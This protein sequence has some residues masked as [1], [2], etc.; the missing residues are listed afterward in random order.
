[1][2]IQGLKGA[3]AKACLYLFISCFFLSS[4]L[5]AGQFTVH[6]PITV[7]R[8]NG[9]PTY[10]EYQFSVDVPGDYTVTI[11]NGGLEDNETLGE[12]VSSSTVKL[13][14]VGIFGPHNFH[15]NISSLTKTV[16]LLENNRLSV[17]I[18]GKPGGAITLVFQGV[19]N[20]NPTISIQ[21]TPE[22]NSAGWNNTDVSINFSCLDDFSG[23]QSC[24]DDL[25]LSNEGRNIE[26]TG[27]AID[28][29]GNSQSAS[30]LLNIDKTV[31]TVAFITPVTETPTSIV[32]LSINDNFDLD[33]GSI[34]LTLDN[35][36]VTSL[37]TQIEAQ[38]SCDFS[39]VELIEADFKVSAKDLADNVGTYTQ[40]YIFDTDLDGDGIGD[41]FDE[42]IDGDGINNDADAFPFDPTESV[43]T[44]NDGIGN[45]MDT[46]DD[47]DG[48]AD[49]DDAFPL[50][51]TE[52][53]D[54]DNDGIGNNADTDDDG[55]GVADTDD[56]FP[57]DPTESVD[58]DNDGIG[59]NADT[60]DDGDGVADT[61][62][63]FPLDPTESVDTDNDGIGNNA[64]TDDDGDGVA[65]TD[66]AFPLDPNESVDT[67]NDG[68][69]NNADIDDDGDGVADAEDAFPLD[70]NESLDTDNDGIGNNADT[71]DDGDG[72][73]DAD[74]AFPLDP[75]E[76]V[77]T[78]ND[79]IGNNADTDDDGDGVADEDDAFPLD[80]NESLDTDND[81]IGNNADIDDDG[82]GFSD[83]EEID[84][85]SDPL[86]PNSVPNSDQDTDGDGIPDSQDPDIDGDGV[87]N[88]EDTFPYDPNE[89]SD[90]D[91]DGTGDNSDPD[92][93]GDDVVNSIDKF[94]ND[95]NESNDLDGDGIGD[96]SDP[97]I[98]GDGVNNEEDSFPNNSNESSDI[99]SDGIGDN[100]DDDI[101]GDG[102]VN[103]S[104]AY[105]TD[106]SR[107]VLPL[108]TIDS[109]K[110][111]TTVGVSPVLVQGTVDTLGVLTVNG[112]VIDATDGFYQTFVE[113]EEGHNTVVT[114]LTGQDGII[115]TAS[116]SISLDKTP[117][118]ITVE[119][120]QD[121]QVVY[122]PKI[123]V[124]GLINDIVRGT[125]EATQAV[126]IVNGVDA[127]I[128]NRTY[129]AKGIE[130]E[131][132]D[133]LIT[134]IARDQAGNTAEKEFNVTYKILTERKLVLNS[135][136]NQTAQLGE[137]LENPLE[138]KVLGDDGQPVENKNVVFRIIQ[139]SGLLSSGPSDGE[140]LLAEDFMDRGLLAQTDAEGIA[141]VYYKLGRRIGVSNHKVR[142][143]V[144]GYEDEVIFSA[145]ATG[146]KPTAVTVNSGNNQ[147]GATGQ[148]L[149]NPFVV[150]VIDEG[151][152]WVE[153]AQV[154]FSVKSGGGFL[155]NGQKTYTATTDSDG[156]ASAQLTLGGITG[157][158]KQIVVAK[159]LGRE[160]GE[161]EVTSTFHASA[162][163][164][165]DPGDTSVS[166]VVLD[167]Q[168]TP[169]P[170]VTVRVDG[171]TRSA[172]AD[173]EGRFKIENVPVGPIHLIADG[174]TATVE[175]EWPTLA[176]N[177][178]TVS[179]ND[180]P[181]PSP[182]YMVKL[183]META[184]W[185][186]EEDVEVTI[187]EVPGF[188]LEIPAGSVTFPDGSKEGYVSVTAVNNNTVPMAPPNGMQPQF[189]VTIQPTGALFDPP[190]R[191]TLPNVD[192]YKPGE[193]TEMYSFD[194]D[195]EEFV[196]IGL[197]TV[198]EDGTVIEANEGVGVIRA[199]WHCGSQSGGSGCCE[200][201]N[202]EGW[203]SEDGCSYRDAK[204]NCECVTKKRPGTTKKKNDSP[205]DC[206]DYL[207]NGEFV[208][209]ETEIR[210]EEFQ[211]SGDCK[212][213]LC[214]GVTERFEPS[215]KK[216]DDKPGD[217]TQ[218][219]CVE[220][221]S[222][223]SNSYTAESPNDVPEDENP[224]DC[225]AWQCDGTELG[226]VL[227]KEQLPYEYQ[228]RNKD[229]NYRNDCATY[230][231]TG[232]EPPE[233]DRILDPAD[234]PDDKP[235]DCNYFSCEE[236]GSYKTLLD[237]KD[238]P[239]DEILD[240]C[241]IKSFECVDAGDG[242]GTDKEVIEKLDGVHP[243][244]GLDKGNKCKLCK[245][246]IKEDVELPETSYY[247]QP[248][249]S[250]PQPVDDFATRVKSLFRAND[251]KLELGIAAKVKAEACCNE[252]RGIDE[253]GSYT[254]SA[255][256]SGS[257]EISWQIWPAF[258]SSD[259]GEF[260]GC[261][262]LFGCFK[263]SYEYSVG[264]F[265]EG[266]ISTSGNVG[267]KHNSC[268]PSDSCFFGS[269]DADAKLALAGRVEGILCVMTKDVPGLPDIDEACLNL[270]ASVTGGAKA[271]IG[272]LAYNASGCGTGFNNPSVCYDGWEASLT[273]K[274]VYIVEGK[275]Y[276][277][278]LNIGAD[279][280]GECK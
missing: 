60:D 132:G 244:A 212:T 38:I 189:I 229:P 129:V 247:I 47:G 138:L 120:H 21:S 164:P 163:E 97:D 48:V 43:D 246:G 243:V 176:Y 280:P 16:T 29:A 113:L 119:S 277:P 160:E 197:G 65:D 106:P 233:V 61:D 49:A 6:E 238:V 131:E 205:N 68:I 174:S 54:T 276:G 115:S 75:T 170:G 128:S 187:P 25:I 140:E 111:L 83:V 139:G 230:V 232:N 74:D 228:L 116:I 273:L 198:S 34:Q 253:T 85:G 102:V 245:S 239:E 219:E 20:V 7:Y 235:G 252:V 203:E 125:V 193:Q 4:E 42:D 121:G 255:S 136:D 73:A 22:A 30:L 166:G 237:P 231:C 206:V 186:G 147:R 1:M 145:S 188:K 152:N 156:R 135:G 153:G 101:D 200:S 46:D 275:D 149:P 103:E 169:V 274:G 84:A 192:G 263:V 52:S 17:D 70:P 72:V 158:D 110:T 171:T 240:E 123:A 267:I 250:I 69:G 104:D 57:L 162:F 127:E 211:S 10:S 63:A 248:Q 179:G 213:S 215:D 98:D 178:V 5:I 81:G 201:G 148:P 172:I 71:D 51:P 251:L 64:D 137:I 207:C 185:A 32:E 225:K 142:A 77:D 80:P 26:V 40:S 107:S 66:D 270:E 53:V 44:D 208:F 56:A 180:Y 24:T 249:I 210:P 79:G 50:D 2:R 45:N 109:P 236:V 257:A 96:N 190:A 191:L 95:P 221:D 112:V 141:R 196:V 241:T 67:D 218:F 82:D 222:G 11:Y 177:I 260:G 122:T 272:Q 13:N 118:Y 33:E 262:P 114:R 154:E 216:E 27:E 100:Q 199:G 182:I 39:S 151:A 117:P 226:E 3:F 41:K 87:N 242:R 23:V 59:N 194:H 204:D 86:D 146:K 159:L 254:S 58:T 195:L 143:R 261:P 90:L 36:N 173:S 18:K 265:L 259:K 183:N 76:S 268:T 8:E 271:K 55:D 91:G 150:A 14:G 175:G 134:I 227:A 279:G 9:S 105:P 88:E 209:D 258:P 157:L 19:D 133:N 35:Q 12:Y 89:S 144:V 220:N 278:K 224:Y 92:I 184:V 62:D 37:C 234:H 214:D 93:D 155:Q 264:V 28:R 217:C 99:D 124:T 108:V 31:P 223:I 165:G 181:M 130:L 202:C 126:V 266:S 168:Q 161:I 167:N 78:D 94:P 15:Q 256:L 269:L